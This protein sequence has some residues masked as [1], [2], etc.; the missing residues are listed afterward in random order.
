MPDDEPASCPQALNSS[1]SQF[2]NSS[3]SQFPLCRLGLATRGGTHL[4]VH[5][6][7]VALD[8]GINFLNWCGVPDSLSA[9]IAELGPRRDRVTICVQFE[10]RTA[11]EAEA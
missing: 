9:T 11:P 7:H 2:L 10:A 1:T 3:I 5:D 4:T 8:R 6:I